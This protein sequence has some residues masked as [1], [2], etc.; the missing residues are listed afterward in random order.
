ML[1]IIKVKSIIRLNKLAEIKTGNN[2]MLLNLKIFQ[3]LSRIFMP[4]HLV[5]SNLK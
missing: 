2:I 4:V 5:N 3:K 1:G